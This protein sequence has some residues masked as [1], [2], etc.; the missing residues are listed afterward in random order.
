MIKIYH[1]L[2]ITPIFKL[3]KK[4]ERVRKTIRKKTDKRISHFFE[5]DFQLKIFL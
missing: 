3:N 2:L 4:R 1:H 5:Q